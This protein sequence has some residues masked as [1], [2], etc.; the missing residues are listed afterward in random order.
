MNKHE[1]SKKHD[2][3]STVEY[4]K[5]HKLLNDW[6]RQNDITERCAVHHRDDTEETRQYNA[7]HYELWGF[8]EDG[9]FEYGKYVVFMTQAEHARYHNKGKVVSEE[10]RIK[11]ST[12]KAGSNSPW[13]GKNLSEATRTKL[14]I[15]HL[16]K[17]HSEETLSKISAAHKGISALYNTYK[18]NGG[19]LKWREFQKALKNGEITFEMQPITVYTK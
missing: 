1:W 12:S 4:K 16:G 5:A 19:I 2:R 18:N 17:R 13:Y 15:A 3:L 8:N 7:K 9:T 11:M 14:S 6:K 10:T